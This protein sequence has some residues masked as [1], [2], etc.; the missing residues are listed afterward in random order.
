MSASTLLGAFR[1]DW[2][3]SLSVRFSAAPRA[4]KEADRIS[5]YLSGYL[6]GALTDRHPE[7]TVRHATADLSYAVN[8]LVENAVKYVDGGELGIEVGFDARHVLLNQST[9]SN[10]AAAKRYQQRMSAMLNSD[11]TEL[12]VRMV[13]LRVE[14]GNTEGSGLGLL[15]LMADYGAELAFEFKTVAPGMQ[16]ITTQAHLPLRI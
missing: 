5:R 9:L 1:R 11:P 15:S 2:A 8:E 10:A 7:L 4:W 16:R 12:I 14:L 6:R 13:E 3:A